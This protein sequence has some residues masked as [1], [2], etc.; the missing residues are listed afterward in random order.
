M[1]KIENKKT[2]ITL[3]EAR[4]IKGKSNPAKIIAEQRKELLSEKKKNKH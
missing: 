1:E 3:D 2:R 4:K